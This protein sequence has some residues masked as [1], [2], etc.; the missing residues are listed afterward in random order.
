MRVSGGV[1]RVCGGGCGGR[2]GVGGCGGRSGVGG[3]GRR[4]VWSEGVWW[5][6]ALL[7]FVTG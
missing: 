1:V 3:C 7:L 6:L 2:G 5:E 4:E